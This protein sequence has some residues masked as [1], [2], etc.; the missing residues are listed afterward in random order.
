MNHDSAKIGTEIGGRKMKRI[1]VY[2]GSNLGNKPEYK[3]SA[4]NL[5]KLLAMENLEL[6]YG[7]SRIGLMGEVA[8]EVLMYGGRAVGVM[9]KG[10]FPENIIKED[11][12]ELIWTQDMRERKKT[13]A[14]RSDGFIALPGGVGTYEEL[15]EMLS[16]AQ[17]KIHK[18]PIGILNTAH[19]FDPLL[20]MIQNTI[21]AGFMNPTNIGLLLVDTDP[22]KLLEKMRNFTAPELGVKWKQLEDAGKKE[23]I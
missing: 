20:E 19:F 11:L 22:K 16:F 8:K 15:F 3:E 12:T 17:L 13:M 10:L 7:G 5:G 6:I 14:E 1:C 9:P 21:N 4:V 18:K 2:S 23:E